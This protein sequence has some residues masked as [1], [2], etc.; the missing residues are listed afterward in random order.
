MI[1]GISWKKFEIIFLGGFLGN[2]GGE[3]RWGSSVS[4]NL[5]GIPNTA[6]MCCGG[7]SRILACLV[8]IW[9]QKK[10]QDFSWDL[11]TKADC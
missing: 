11:R 3:S 5:A 9:S 1:L 2:R 7:S 4:T 6:S 10:S 8:K